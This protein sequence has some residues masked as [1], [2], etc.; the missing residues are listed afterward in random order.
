L[1]SAAKVAPEYFGKKGSEGE[2]LQWSSATLVGDHRLFSSCRVL[3]G[4]KNRLVG[5]CRRTDKLW[6]IQ[7]T[8]FSLWL[9]PI[10]S[11][12]LSKRNS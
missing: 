2:N 11:L 10:I 7:P 3:L 12:L 9:K 8:M 1:E 6:P 4:L 5:G